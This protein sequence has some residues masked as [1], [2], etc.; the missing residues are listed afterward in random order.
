VGIDVVDLLDPRSEGKAS[1]ARL[2]A[3]ILSRDEARR[4]AEAEDPDLTLWSLW[5]G[6]EAGFK[7]VTLLRGRAPVFRHAAFRVELPEGA[8][9]GSGAAEAGG[10]PSGRVSFEEFQLPLRLVRLGSCLV[11][12]AWSPC[13]RPVEVGGLPPDL[14]WGADPLD[15]IAHELG[16]GGDTLEA[17]C[18]RHFRAAEARAVHSWPSALARLAVRRAA[19][20]TLATDEGRLAVVCAEGARGRVPPELHYDDAPLADVALSL[21]HHGG[22]VG[23]ALRVAGA[24]S[25][26]AG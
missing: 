10:A 8:G 19:A 17:L 24:G 26:G 20:R 13:P 9:P 22:W 21:S 23:W 16:V 18:K 11:A 7:V 14:H 1:D 6:K 25:V 15:V 3:R 5:A 4:L 12:L 2:I